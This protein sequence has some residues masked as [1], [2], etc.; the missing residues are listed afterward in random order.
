ME[1]RTLKPT[2]IQAALELVWKV[3][4]EYEAPDYSEEGVETFSRCIRDPAFVEM[5]TFYGAFGEDGSPAGV[6]ATRSGGAHLAM[7]FVK[8]ESQR[9]G[10]GRKLFEEALKNNPSDS[11][12]VNSSPFAVGIYRRL[13]F[14]E[15]DAEQIRDGIRYTPMIYRK[16]PQARPD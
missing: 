10:V 3:F 12:T 5:L 14:S 4:L 16:N 6:L 8:S 13:G 2:E 1:I 9:K 7:F 11:M 15:T